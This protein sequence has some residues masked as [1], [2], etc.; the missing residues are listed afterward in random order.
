MGIKGL[1]QYI[2]NNHPHLNKRV[3]QASFEGRRIAFDCNNWFYVMRSAIRSGEINKLNVLEE[4]VDEMKVDQLW[5][6]DIM[7]RL[8]SFVSNGIT[9]VLIFDGPSPIQKTKTKLKRTDDKKKALEKLEAVNTEYE[10][11]SSS[12]RHLLADMNELLDRKRKAMCSLSHIPADSMKMVINFLRGA[13]FPVVESNQEGERLGAALC[14]EGIVAAMYSADGDSLTHGCPILIR[15]VGQDIYSKDGMKATFELVYLSEV[16]DA[17][18]MTSET[19]TELCIMAGCDYNDNMEKIAFV[20]ALGLIKTYGSIDKLPDKYDTSCLIHHECRELFAPLPYTE[21]LSDPNVTFDCHPFTEETWAHF[22]QYEMSHFAEKTRRLFARLVPPQ[23]FIH[24][25]TINVSA[26]F[27]FIEGDML[28]GVTEIVERSSSVRRQRSLKAKAKNDTKPKVIETAGDFVI[29]DDV[30][31]KKPAFR[32]R[33]SEDVEARKVKEK[34]K[35]TD[36]AIEPI[37]QR[38]QWDFELD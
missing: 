6:A 9:P 8:L 14:R 20:R 22:D 32:G 24:L 33:T 19:F 10:T 1:W 7:R 13:G 3:P 29:I 11:M 38:K 37:G 31:S 30:P 21:M 4:P 35:R 23:N 12:K 5:I 17:L 15:D 18:E 27:C 34:S 16:L 28:D 2:K 26:D 36:A 25:M